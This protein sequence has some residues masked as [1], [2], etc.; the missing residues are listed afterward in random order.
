[1]AILRLSFV[2]SLSSLVALY[3]VWQNLFH[4]RAARPNLLRRLPGASELLRSLSGSGI[5]AWRR[6]RAAFHEVLVLT[7]VDDTLWSS[8]AWR[9]GGKA[10]GGV[11]EDLSR[12][13][14]Y[15]GIGALYFLLS[16]GPHV[17]AAPVNKFLPTC[18]APLVSP[19]FETCQ[20]GDARRSLAGV[21]GRDTDSWVLGGGERAK[22]LQDYR[23]KPAEK[24]PP[25]PPRVGLLTARA[26]STAMRSFTRSASFYTAVAAALIH[27]ARQ[28][29]GP[30]VEDWGRVRFENNMELLRDVIG[31]QHSRGR[32]KVTGFKE[33]LE[34]FPT[35]TPVFVGD[36]G[37]RDV[38]AAA[39]MALF[40][41]EKLAAVFV[42]V[43]FNNWGN[44]NPDETE[45]AVATARAAPFT[46][47]FNNRRIPALQLAY[48]VQANVHP[49]D[50]K[51]EN[52]AA[53]SDT[54]L[55]SAGMHV[56]GV[57]KPLMIAYGHHSRR[58]RANPTERHDRRTNK[59]EEGI[60]DFVA[61]PIF[62]LRFVDFTVKRSMSVRRQTTSNPFRKLYSR[63][64]TGLKNSVSKV[65][66]L[67]AEEEQLR[68]YTDLRAVPADELG[69][70]S[71][72]G[73]PFIPYRTVLGAGI[74]A[75]ILEM[76]TLQDLINLA[77]SSIR[78]F[79]SLGPPQSCAQKQ[80]LEDL[81]FDLRYMLELTGEALQSVHVENR[82]IF[83]DGVAAMGTF[84]AK[85]VD[86]CIPSGP[87]EPW[88]VGEEINACLALFRTPRAAGISPR[89]PTDSLPEAAGLGD[90]PH[91]VLPLARV[92]CTFV[93][94]LKHWRSA[95][96]DETEMLSLEF[97]VALNEAVDMS[98]RP[99]GIGGQPVTS[100]ANL[101]GDSTSREV[102]RPSGSLRMATVPMYPLS[103]TEV[104]SVLSPSLRSRPTSGTV[105][106]SLPVPPGSPGHSSFPRVSLTG[107]PGD[108]ADATSPGRGNE[109][110]FVS[111]SVLS[112][113]S[114]T[115][116]ASDPA[117][118]SPDRPHLYSTA[119]AERQN[120][121]RRI[122]R[123]I[124]TSTQAPAA[125]HSRSDSL[126]IEGTTGS[127]SSVQ[128]RG[129]SA[130]RQRPQ[131]RIEDGATVSPFSPG[132]STAAGPSGKGQASVDIVRSGA[133][134]AHLS[135][136]S[137]AALG[138]V[139]S[140]APS[141][142]PFGGLRKLLAT[143]RPI[144]EHQKK[145]LG[146]AS[147][148]AFMSHLLYEEGLMHIFATV[149]AW[150]EDGA[151]EPLYISK[152]HLTLDPAEAKLETLR[153][154]E[155]DNFANLGM[156]VLKRGRGHSTY[157]FDR[158]QANHRE[159]A[160]SYAGFKY[161]SC[162]P[163]EA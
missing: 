77:V 34:Q 40:A 113:R 118:M 14:T 24:R 55:Y 134:S 13:Q 89:D 122:P 117:P 143:M 104:A 158:L 25:L 86:A 87:A 140:A 44:E 147:P 28:I 102:P 156:G 29:Y 152:M 76:I 31:G 61:L 72:P 142:C 139:I 131:G 153:K 64:S 111:P 108:G 133:L 43:V 47:R 51:P 38:E 71:D 146:V 141:D 15:P 155:S 132:R 145:L 90:I 94:Q 49:S 97:S 137:R 91:A 67:W 119:E 162:N 42:H 85:A 22:E 7:D 123:A 128:S 18:P 26:S 19:L 1:M 115:S 9:L 82:V 114:P 60:R 35:Q 110:N 124:A 63:L 151:R 73:V 39:G 92:V 52:F 74:S 130:D 99:F 30:G 68:S 154:R 48:D 3:S 41:Q 81:Y 112:P 106:L 120:L 88:T 62:F 116:P 17:T 144:C 121:E 126:Q 6:V 57:M 23:R 100:L 157:D 78:D 101:S 96:A 103:D 36:S 125:S 80:G 59:D 20:V 84:Y 5:S 54:H 107:R 163:F 75:F 93:D 136:A 58:Q 27:G 8:G 161:L 79:R 148:C 83:E 109:S 12:G 37:E 45:Q 138:E 127:P 56:A 159:F 95:G 70:S 4:A 33:A 150:Y 21:A 2:F 53:L 98:N 129:A 11:D 16:A 149:T 65:V 135:W 105:N 160:R 50:P 46:L 10:L 32:A 66:D 69:G